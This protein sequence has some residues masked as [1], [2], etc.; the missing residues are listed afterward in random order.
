MSMH[1]YENINKCRFDKFYHPY[2]LVDVESIL[3]N[4]TR[5]A[6]NCALFKHNPSINGKCITRK[7]PYKVSSIQSN[8]FNVEEEENKKTNDIMNNIETRST[9]SSGKTF[10]KSEHFTPQ[11]AYNTYFAV[12]ERLIRNNNQNT[13]I[14]ENTYCDYD[15]DTNGSTVP[16]VAPPELCPIVKNN[17]KKTGCN[18]IIIPEFIH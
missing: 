13:Q 7:E 4:Q 6:S 8:K 10:L 5:P 17:I 9:A 18:G 14:V 15:V 16:K 3:R 12:D 11:E 2:D 1:P